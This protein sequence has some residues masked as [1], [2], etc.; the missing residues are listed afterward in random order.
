VTEIAQREPVA[1]VHA[2]PGGDYHSG[3]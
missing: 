1:S 2:A 3:A